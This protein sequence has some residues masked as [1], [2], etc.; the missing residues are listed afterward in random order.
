MGY[1]IPAAVGAKVASPES[2]VVD[3]DGD[4]S[5]SMTVSSVL[6]FRRV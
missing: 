6:R 2:I 5:A 3:V 4:A 1:G